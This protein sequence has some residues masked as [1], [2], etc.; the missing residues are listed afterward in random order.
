MPKNRMKI[1][2]IAQRHWVVPGEQVVWLT[3]PEGHVGSGVGATRAAPHRTTAPA[4]AGPTPDW[5]LPTA[6]VAHGRF[7]LDE[8]AHDPAVWGWAHA[9]RPDQLA[10]RFADLFT[11]GRDECWLLITNRR[12]ALVVEGELAIPGEPESGGLL[13]RVRSLGQSRDV[14]PLV[15]WW[16]G[17]VSTVRAFTPAP[18]G[19][20]VTPEWFLRLEFADGSA[21][22]LRDDQAEQTVRTLHANF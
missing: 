6:A 17:P 10:V 3:H 11:A 8:W 16:E 19:R 18:L 4:L 1:G 13:G 21:F 7:H 22:D 14:P 9:R 15:T 2:E 20:H 12:V 5:P